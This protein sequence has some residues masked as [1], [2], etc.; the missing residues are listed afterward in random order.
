MVTA[1]AERI[2]SYVVESELGRGAFGVVYRA[3]H[4]QRPDA[5]VALKVVENRGNLDRMML[6]P[7]LLSGLRHPCIVRLDDYF[8]DNDRLVLALELIPGEDL[9]ACVD[10][11]ETFGQAEVRDLLVQ[12]AGALAEAHAHNIVHRDIKLSNVLV[13]RMGGRTRFV[14]TDFGV[15]RTAEGIQAEKHTGGTYLF[16]APEQLRGR[17]GPQSDLWAL[18]VVAYRL[19]TGQMPFNGANIHALSNQIFY[20]TPMPPSKCSP[21]PIDA[22]LEAVVFHLLEKSLTDRTASAEELLREVGYRGAPNAV[23]SRPAA[24]RTSAGRRSP[25]RRLHRGMLWLRILLTGFLLLYATQK[26]F[27]SGALL[28]VGVVLFYLG[29]RRERWSAAGRAAA[30]T[31]A[32][33]AMAAS[34][35][36]PYTGVEPARI[37]PIWMAGAVGAASKPAAEAFGQSVALVAAVMGLVLFGAYFILV[38]FAAPLGALCL[39]A[40]RR[41]QRALAL[42]RAALEAGDDPEKYLGAMRAF[43]DDRFEDVAFHLKYVEALLARGRLKE[44]AVEAKVLLRQDPYNFSGN[45]LLANAYSGLGL[46]DDGIAVC[47]AYLIVAGYC[48]EFAE[49]KQQCLRRK[50]A[51]S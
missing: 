25:D 13:D 21:Q 23:A 35:V 48:F 38:F 33:A 5:P 12:M 32:L 17:P 28:I 51:P 9:K 19:L 50:G 10:R 45:L 7:A 44:V 6:E 39:A 36:V 43:L 3:H 8:L 29:C 30:I 24:S 49:L 4:V 40:L 42:R 22:D 27:I 46:F 47:D 37:L 11:G 15:G 2:G 18:G 34:S 20:A 1:T 14:L 26:G 16:M 41:R 31:A